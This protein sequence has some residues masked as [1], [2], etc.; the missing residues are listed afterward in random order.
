MRST[1]TQKSEHDRRRTL[2]LNILR[3][4]P[5]LGIQIMPLSNLNSVFQPR[6]YNVL[7]HRISITSIEEKRNT[8]ANNNHNRRIGSHNLLKSSSPLYG[9]KHTILPFIIKLHSTRSQPGA[10]NPL[11]ICHPAN[12]SKFNNEN[13]RSH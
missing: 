3:H 11:M 12:P 6:M 1:R 13:S 8:L 7:L 5:C 9:T 4:Y 2:E 10:T